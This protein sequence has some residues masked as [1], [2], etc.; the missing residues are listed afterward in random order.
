MKKDKLKNYAT[1]TDS[2]LIP[3]RIIYYPADR[4]GCS[5]WRMRLPALIQHSEILENIIINPEF[6]Q[7]IGR[8]YIQRALDARIIPTIE[9]TKSTTEWIYDTDDLLSKDLIPDYNITKDD[10]HDDTEKKALAVMQVCNHVRVSTMEL[11]KYYKPIVNVPVLYVPNRSP[12]IWF[13]GLRNEQ[14]CLD[15]MN[16]HRNRPRVLWAGSPSHLDILNKGVDDDFSHVIGEMV[17][18]AADFQFVFVGAYPPEFQEFIDRGYA[19]FYPWIAIYQYPIMLDQLEVNIAI[20]PLQDNLFNS[21]KSNIKLLEACYLGMPAI[22]QDM[23][24]Y[25]D[26]FLKFRSGKDLSDM[27]YSLKKDRKMYKAEVKRH[28]EYGLNNYL[29]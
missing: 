26:A 2:D 23:V 28:F 16:K 27:L 21:C 18:L 4:S 1:L 13:Y 5:V 3:S 25:D 6:Y 14:R 29:D 10:W 11:V 7:S 20:A 22:C 24:T 17:K 8:A 15:L 9:A 19:E 12:K